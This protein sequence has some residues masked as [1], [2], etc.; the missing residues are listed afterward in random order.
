[1]ASA[2]AP[3]RVPGTASPPGRSL[4]VVGALDAESRQAVEVLFANGVNVSLFAPSAGDA[5]WLDSQRLE[6]VSLEMLQGDEWVKLGMCRG[7]FPEIP[8]DCEAVELD[9]EL[10]KMRDAIVIGAD[11]RG[12]GKWLTVALLMANSLAFD[13]PQLVESCPRQ[14][15]G[16]GR[17]AHKKFNRK[18]GGGW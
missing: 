3:P 16:K 8:V 4:E 5:A 15:T 2:L 18:L 12:S 1:M 6:S 13:M 17:K 10:P 11:H 14:A 9:I 7:P